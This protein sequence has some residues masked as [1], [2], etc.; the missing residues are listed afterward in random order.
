MRFP[1]WNLP[2]TK[3]KLCLPLRADR[4]YK[5]RVNEFSLYESR[6]RARFAQKHSRVA[7]VDLHEKVP[8]IGASFVRDY[9]FRFC[10]PGREPRSESAV[11]NGG[12][13]VARNEQGKR[14]PLERRH[15]DVCRTKGKSSSRLPFTAKQIMSQS[16]KL[17]G[18]SSVQ[19]DFRARPLAL[20]TAHALYV[21]IV[22]LNC[23]S[24]SL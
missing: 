5:F 10:N 17:W 21:L 3:I 9:K 4:K 18:C 6:T 15:V 7:R 1:L 19:N 11:G 8:I 2:S 13:I 20:R 14:F 16:V 12:G 23:G 22:P 24:A